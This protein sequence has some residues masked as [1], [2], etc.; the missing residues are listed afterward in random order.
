MEAGTMD[1]GG[2]LLLDS[3][4]D[5][6]DFVYPNPAPPFFKAGV[7]VW[8]LGSSEAVVPQPTFNSPTPEL[9]S[10]WPTSMVAGAAA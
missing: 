8:L 6:S 3:D 1:G 5:S 2:A 10:P 9:P 4:V 7:G